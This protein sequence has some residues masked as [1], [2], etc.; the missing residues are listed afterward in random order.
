MNDAPERYGRVR[1]S[2]VR[3]AYNDLRTAVRAGDIEAAQEALDRYEQ[4]ADIVFDERHKREPSVSGRDPAVEYFEQGESYLRKM[5]TLAKEA[6]D[7]ILTE[8][9]E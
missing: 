1:V 7:D 8:G 3:A 4:W 5:V 2:K 9:G 6:S